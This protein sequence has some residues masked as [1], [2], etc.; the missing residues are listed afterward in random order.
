MRRVLIVLALALSACGA[1]HPT[2]SQLRDASC[3]VARQAC[4]LCDATED[5]QR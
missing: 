3:H 2:L 5:P 4:A 1:S